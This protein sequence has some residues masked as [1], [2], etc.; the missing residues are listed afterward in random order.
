MLL[1]SSPIHEYIRLVLVQIQS[2][3]DKCTSARGYDQLSNDQTYFLTHQIP[4]WRINGPSNQIKRKRKC[5]GDD[6]LHVPLQ[7]LEGWELM[8]SPSTCTT[9]VL[10]RPTGPISS[11]DWGLQMVRGRCRTVAEPD[12]KSY[13]FGT[14]VC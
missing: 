2:C 14:V 13:F 8:R 3:T 1:T 11:G 12:R 4:R 10:Q 6:V 5:E 7:A 9:A